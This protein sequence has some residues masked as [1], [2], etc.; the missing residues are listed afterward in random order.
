MISL[1]IKDFQCTAAQKLHI[2]KLLLV[3]WLAKA[4]WK[5]MLIFGFHYSKKVNYLTFSP[6][7]FFTAF[8][9]TQHTAP[10]TTPLN[11]TH[12]SLCKVLWQLRYIE[13]RHYRKWPPL[14][15]WWCNYQNWYLT[16]TNSK[17]RRSF[18]WEPWRRLRWLF[19]LS[20]T[21]PEDFNFDHFQYW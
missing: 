3:L 16:W 12:L 4:K 8:F 11:I 6:Q 17:N 7:F 13:W 21:S 10:F 19:R 15:D 20:S 1:S 2:P 5:T 18:W 9:I 14:F